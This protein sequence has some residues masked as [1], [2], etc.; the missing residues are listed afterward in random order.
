MSMSCSTWT[1]A[2]IPM[3][4]AASTSASMIVVL[5]RVLTPLVGSSSRMISGRS[6]KALATSRSFLSPWDSVRAVAERVREAEEVGHLRHVLPDG[7]VAGERGQETPASAQPGDDGHGQRLRH[8][9]RG[10]DVD[11][12]KAP[13]HAQ[14]GQP[15][16]A[17]PAM[18]RALKRTVPAWATT[19]L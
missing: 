2:L 4:R 7:A 6:A 13:R 8:G 17:D 5:S 1:M 12:L 16:G 9:E 3:R 18:S 15:D 11:E 19:C 10:E 14:R